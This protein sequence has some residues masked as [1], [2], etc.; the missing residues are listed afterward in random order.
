MTITTDMVKVLRE[1]TGAGILDAKKALDAFGGD[2]D[3]AA[4]HLREKGLAAADKKSSREARQGLVYSYIHGDP[5]RVGVLVEVNCETDFVARTEAFRELTRNI[6]LQIAALHPRYV[7]EEDIPAD[8]S[9]HERGI[10]T[11]QLTEDKAMMGKP[12][13]V[14]AKIVDGKLGKWMDEVV[15]LRQ[16]YVK[17][18][19]KPVGELVRSAMAELGENIVVRRFV[20]F[21]LGE[22]A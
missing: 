1:R 17:D 4:L 11:A 21:E 3:Q 20:R 9:E 14:K 8:I 19:D 5:G 16:S 18:L 6:A 22:N 7:R 10:F 13:A 15:L 2:M 12:D